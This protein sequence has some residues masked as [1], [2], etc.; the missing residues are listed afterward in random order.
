MVSLIHIL[1]YNVPADS[2]YEVFKIAKGNMIKAFNH[3]VKA[4]VEV[5]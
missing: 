4:M 3:F 5:F 2:I 1:A